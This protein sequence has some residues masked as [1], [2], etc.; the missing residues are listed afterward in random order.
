MADPIVKYAE[1]TAVGDG[2]K[3]VWDFNFA[4]AEGT[5]GYISKD[6]VKAFT[7]TPAGL[8]TDITILSAMWVSP[9]SI[10]IT[11]AIASQTVL[12][13]YRNT[14]KDKPLVNYTTN[15]IITEANLDT[16]ARQ[17]IYAS[18]EV[19]DSF[20]EAQE[21]VDGIGESVSSAAASAASA[22]ASKNTAVDSA[23]ASLNGAS[24][25]LNAAI[26]ATQRAAAAVIS[27]D[28]A[29]S[30]ANQA[31]GV[32][33]SFDTRYL[34]AKASDPA[35]DNQGQPLNPGALYFNTVS[36]QQ[37]LVYNGL[38][39][40]WGPLSNNTVLNGNG[41]PASSLGFTNDFYIDNVAFLMYGPKIG[42]VWGSGHSLAGPTGDGTGNVLG[43]ATSVDSTLALYDGT[44]G[45]QIKGS[46][47]TT[48]V[49][50]LTAGVPTAA[51]AAVDYV[52]PSAYASANGHTMSTARILGR[53]AAGTGQAQ[54]ITLGTG[55][56]IA[57]TTL[58]VVPAGSTLLATLTPA[59]GTV[60][61]DLLNVFNST[62]DSYE[63]V[64]SGA[65][66]VLSPSGDCSLV[67]Q[68]A[69][70]GVLDTNAA[71]YKLSVGSSAFSI[72]TSETRSAGSG[73]GATVK[74]Q[75]ANSTGAKVTSFQSWSDSRTAFTSV[76]RSDGYV[77]GAVSGLRL[78]WTGISGGSAT[79]SFAAGSTVRVYGHSKV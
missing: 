41:P 45:T 60:A 33:L 28:E 51:V 42:S 16:T 36:P 64:V 48:T 10:R 47:L 63:I 62:Y 25:S 37:M 39:S 29:E 2:V 30:F 18:A 21:I 8:R 7:V 61:I 15:A 76:A 1:F 19:L 20:A 44:T 14:P 17:A 57:G 11:P 6:H 26:V 23:Q 22:L 54:E 4:G 69:V 12:T 40:T 58:S 65:L 68:L 78:F 9:T 55:F 52:A 66:P 70:G 75:N 34:G 5:P 72:L 77:G 53:F 24:E 59:A 74:L 32:F 50:K 38:T 71:N 67:C 56:N 73:C 43:P 3:T 27:A 49:V 31:E 79:V 46:S 13:I 35:L